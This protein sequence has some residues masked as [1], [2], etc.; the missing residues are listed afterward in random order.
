[1]IPVFLL[2]CAAMLCAGVGNLFLSKG[3]KQVGVLASWRPAVA[4]RFF[5][6]SVLNRNVELGVLISCGYFFLWLIVLSLADVSWALPMNGVE[7]LMVAFLAQIFLKE[8]VTKERWIG[9]GLISLGIYFMI[10][11]W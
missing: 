7:Y 6:R 2:L 1:M 11:S 8:R 5:L 3:M 9:I 4:W 10:G